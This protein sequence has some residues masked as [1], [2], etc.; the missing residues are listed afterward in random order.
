MKTKTVQNEGG[1]VDITHSEGRNHAK[2]CTHRPFFYEKGRTKRSEVREK[3]DGEGFSWL[4]LSPNQR[5]G[6]THQ[7]VLFRITVD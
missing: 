1:P 3:G 7:A 5:T 6:S 2:G 4:G